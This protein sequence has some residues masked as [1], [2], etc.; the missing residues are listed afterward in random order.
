MPPKNSNKKYVP[1]CHNHRKEYNKRNKGLY[2]ITTA[3]NVIR[4]WPINNS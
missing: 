4:K 3:S 1:L 2:I